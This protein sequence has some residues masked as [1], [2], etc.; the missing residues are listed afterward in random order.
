[1]KPIVRRIA[2]FEMDVRDTPLDTERQ[3]LV[4]TVEVHNSVVT[5][6]TNVHALGYLRTPISIEGADNVGPGRLI[7]LL[8]S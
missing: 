4:E 2:D 7:R 1:M 8:R 3:K 6:Y 5:G